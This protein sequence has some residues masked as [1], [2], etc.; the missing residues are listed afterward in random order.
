MQTKNNG[1]IN[2]Y[3]KNGDVVSSGVFNGETGRIRTIRPGRITVDFD[4]RYAGYSLDAAAE[5][6]LSYAT[7]IHKALGSE[8][9]TVIIPLLAAHKILLTRNLLYTAVTRAKRRVV[10]VGCLL[11]TSRCV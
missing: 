9:D 2:L 10:L 3:D 11:Y 4:G 1:S 6:D 5:L 7:T 8:Y